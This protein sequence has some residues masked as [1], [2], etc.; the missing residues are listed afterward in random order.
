MLTLCGVLAT[1]AVL[2]PLSPDEQPPSASAAANANATSTGQHR[3][4]PARVIIAFPRM[5]QRGAD[6][7]RHPGIA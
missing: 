3:A 7:V 2:P 5:I 1:A 6:L 4:L